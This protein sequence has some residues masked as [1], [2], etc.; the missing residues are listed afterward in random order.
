MLAHRL[1]TQTGDQL[2]MLGRDLLVR[3]VTDD[4]VEST[5]PAPRADVVDGRDLNSS[6]CRRV[7]LVVLAHHCCKFESILALVI[8]HAINGIPD[9]ELFPAQLT[10]EE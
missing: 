2:P 4:I 7:P 5:V 1:V 8:G 3:L 6:V 9:D 10:P